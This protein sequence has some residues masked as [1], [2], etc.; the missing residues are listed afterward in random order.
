MSRFW[1]VIA[2]GLVLLGGV[3]MSRGVELTVSVTPWRGTLKQ[4]LYSGPDGRYYLR[5]GMRT[6]LALFRPRTR[7]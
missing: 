6:R 3:R 7:I 1:R 4:Q 2:T 5:G